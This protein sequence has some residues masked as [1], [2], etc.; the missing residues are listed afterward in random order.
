MKGMKVR[1]AKN[2]RQ[3]ARLSSMIP[4]QV[5]LEDHSIVDALVDNIGFGGVK[6]RMPVPIPVGN[7]VRLAIGHQDTML[8]VVAECVWIKPASTVTYDYS[9]GFSFQGVSLE[10]YQKIRNLLFEL[11]DNDLMDL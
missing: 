2:Y 7:L 10:T 6:L 5:L 9:G 3:N 1:M 4:I 8:S 11:A